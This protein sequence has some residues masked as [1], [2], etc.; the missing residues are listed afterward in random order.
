MDIPV[1][2]QVAGVLTALS[3]PNRIVNLCSPGYL[4]LSPT[5]N[6][7]YFGYIPTMDHTASCRGIDCTPLSESH[8]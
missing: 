4:R 7:N 5:C 2:L 3:Y 1:I 8:S 6:M